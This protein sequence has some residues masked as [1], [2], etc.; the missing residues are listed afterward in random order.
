MTDTHGGG[1]A[2]VVDAD[3]GSTADDDDP[4]S[5]EATPLVLL[6]VASFLRREL[7]IRLAHRRQDPSR[8][9]LL[10]NT[11]LVRQAKDLHAASFTAVLGVDR[12]PPTREGRE[13]WER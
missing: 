4:D 2:S 7:P 10:G 3:A 9:P 1:Y 12:H 5:S 8:V 6:Q 11:G 13:A